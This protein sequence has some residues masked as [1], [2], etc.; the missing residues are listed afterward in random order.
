MGGGGGGGGRWA[1]GSCRNHLIHG[2]NCSGVSLKS[3]TD[4]DRKIKKTAK[5]MIN[6]FFAVKFHLNWW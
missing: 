2:N 5:F 1:V 6:I 4:R 3:G